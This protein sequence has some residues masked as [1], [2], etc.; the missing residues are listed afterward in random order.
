MKEY[1]GI[2]V[3]AA[4]VICWHSVLVNDFFKGVFTVVM[5]ELIMYAM[6]RL[7]R[8]DGPLNPFRK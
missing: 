4:M 3:F 8:W 7:Y 5:I 1:L 2:V 6:Y